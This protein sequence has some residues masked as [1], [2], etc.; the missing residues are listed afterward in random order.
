[1]SRGRSRALGF[2][3][4]N[5]L[6]RDVLTC[7]TG[8]MPEGTPVTGATVRRASDTPRG[9]SRLAPRKGWAEVRR[10][11]DQGR[12]STGLWSRNDSQRWLSS[13]GSSCPLQETVVDGMDSFASR[14]RLQRWHSKRCAVGS[15]LQAGQKTI[16]QVTHLMS[17]CWGGH[18]V[19]QCGHTLTS[20][21]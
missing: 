11:S 17:N 6:D 10:K 19:P 14:G 7:D 3:G 8:R 9:D 2:Q 18:R 21:P 15:S 12:V 4:G 13:T 20:G 5:R 1:L 16:S